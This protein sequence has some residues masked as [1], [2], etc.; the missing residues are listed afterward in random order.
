MLKGNLCPKLNWSGFLSEGTRGIWNIQYGQKAWQCLECTKHKFYK[1]IHTFY[2]TYLYSGLLTVISSGCWFS[3]SIIV[4]LSSLGQMHWKKSPIIY[5]IVQH[6]IHFYR[7]QQSTFC[8]NQHDSSL[9]LYI[10]KLGLQLQIKAQNR[11]I[12]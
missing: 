10:Y 1:N 9:N 12:W 2:Y 6:A 5:V 7:Y 11:M 3:I 4:T 8:S